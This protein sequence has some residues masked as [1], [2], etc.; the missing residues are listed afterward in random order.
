MTKR[1][2]FAY[3]KQYDNITLPVVVDAKIDRPSQAGLFSLQTILVSFVL[4]LL[5]S[6]H[7][8][9]DRG[10]LVSGDVVGAVV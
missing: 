7:K 6:Y 2:T 9:A 5:P 4:F 1:K 10:V 8:A 3:W